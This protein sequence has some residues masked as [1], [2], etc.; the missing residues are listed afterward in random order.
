MHHLRKMASAKLAEELQLVSASDIAAQINTAC[1]Q[2]GWAVF[3]D[4]E[5]QRDDELDAFASDDDA[6]AHVARLAMLGSQPHTLALALHY[7]WTDADGGSDDVTLTARQRAIVKAGLRALQHAYV[8]SGGDIADLFEDLAGSV[9][10]D[11]KTLA[12]E[13]DALCDQLAERP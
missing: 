8:A 2:E 5:I 11:D 3:N 6:I 9:E 1:E 10:P 7:G 13:I 12:E 4:C